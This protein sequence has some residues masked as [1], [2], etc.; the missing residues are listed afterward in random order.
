MKYPAMWIRR[1]IAI[2][3]ITKGFGSMDLP[4]K[5]D[6]GE[7]PIIPAEDI[8]MDTFD[9]FKLMGITCMKNNKKPAQGEGGLHSCS[10][11]GD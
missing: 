10:A 11:R 6:V 8:G 3:A 2:T 1:T 5:S 4:P 9:R 7:S